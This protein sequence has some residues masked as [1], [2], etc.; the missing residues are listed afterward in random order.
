MTSFGEE[1]RRL[2][3]S[4][5]VGREMELSIFS[6]FICNMENK[7]RILNISGTG[8]IGKSSLLDQ[9]RRIC[10]Q[11]GIPFFLLD[12]LDFAK[13]PHGFAFRLLALLNTEVLEEWSQE[14]LL[15]QAV[16]QLNKRAQTGRLVFAID[17]YEEMNEL[18]DW[19][20][21]SFLVELSTSIMI[22]LSGHFPL[23]G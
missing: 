19:L 4:F 22:V 2:E 9:F 12:C 14:K 17:T 23:K 13:N 5:F 18:D 10:D 6:Q 11:E 3:E 7:E 15:G 1:I 20:R 21:Q 16:S 8:G